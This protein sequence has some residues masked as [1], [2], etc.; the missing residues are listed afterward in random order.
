MG[1]NNIQKRLERLEQQSNAN[2]SYILFID[3]IS[4]DEPYREQQSGESLKD[5]N[6]YL[7]SQGID[8]LVVKG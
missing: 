8:T 1:T 5:Y 4:H 3:D 7:K 2:N 6:R